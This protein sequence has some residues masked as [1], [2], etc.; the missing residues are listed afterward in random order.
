MASEEWK[1]CRADGPTG[2]DGDT[3]VGGELEETVITWTRGDDGR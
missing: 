1:R 3:L 2:F